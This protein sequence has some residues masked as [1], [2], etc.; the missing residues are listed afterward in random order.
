MSPLKTCRQKCVKVSYRLI[1][2]PEQ[3]LYATGCMLTAERLEKANHSIIKEPASIRAAVWRT[4]GPCAH[5]ILVHSNFTP[6][7]CSSGSTS[8]PGAEDGPLV[9]RQTSLDTQIPACIRDKM[10]NEG[11]LHK[12]TTAASFYSP[13]LSPHHFSIYGFNIFCIEFCT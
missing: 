9:D 3:L 8:C 7:S 5:C 2:K 4:V 10:K 12:Q 13:P 1:L 11:L 6:L